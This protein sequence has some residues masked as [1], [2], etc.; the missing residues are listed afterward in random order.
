MLAWVYLG[1]AILFEVVATSLMKSTQGFTQLWPTVAVVS[2][3]LIAFFMLAKS[4]QQ[5]MSIGVGYAIWSALG[6]T[7]IVVV[8]ALFL[9]EALTPVKIIG[10][11]LVVAGVITLNLGGAH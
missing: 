6:T 2:G 11:A 7:V 4:L 1:F 5:G 10:V 9:N 8:G 3:Y